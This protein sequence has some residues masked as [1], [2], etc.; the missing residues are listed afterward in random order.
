MNLK[1]L[2]RMFNRLFGF[3]S[4]L[5]FNVL[6]LYTDCTESFENLPCK[7]IMYFTCKVKQ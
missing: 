2:G 5:G 6:F 4:F 1:T 3:F 7:R